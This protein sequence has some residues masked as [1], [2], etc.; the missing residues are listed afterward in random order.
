[1]MI[2]QALVRTLVEEKIEGTEI[3]IVSVRVVPTN[4]IRVFVDALD[5]LDVRACVNI[6]RHIEGSL[7]RE[8]EDYELEVSSP[9]L[10]EPF[11]HPLQYKKN[12]GREIKVT[13]S[14]GV[15]VKG[16]LVSFDGDTIIVQPE[17]KKKKEE[18]EA[19]TIP[20]SEIKE[21]KTVISFK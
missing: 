4:R 19:V 9:G 6:S 12:V 1:M 20:L 17:Q 13:M 15:S 18:V 8:V 16:Q 10:T 21:A 5:G 11:Q 7:D 3:F 2:T 14:D